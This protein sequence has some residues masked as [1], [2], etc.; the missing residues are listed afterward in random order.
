M[1]QDKDAQCKE[2][3]R[4]TMSNLMASALSNSSCAA[5]IDFDAID[6]IVRKIL[7][8]KFDPM[9]DNLPPF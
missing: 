4:L 5:G 1:T 2:K 3:Y 6:K 7:S 9:D 8:A